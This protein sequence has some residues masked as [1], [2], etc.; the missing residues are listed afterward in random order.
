MP[1]LRGHRPHHPGGHA[2][3]AGRSG[4]PRKRHRRGDPHCPG[5][6]RRPAPHRGGQGLHRHR[7]P[8]T[9]PPSLRRAGQKSLADCKP[10]VK[11]G[12]SPFLTVSRKARRKPCFSR[13]NLRLKEGPNS[14]I[15]LQA[16]SMASRKSLWSVKISCL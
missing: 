15:H 9:L 3:G 13:I 12:R 16:L 10:F 4:Q 1:P 5:G 14:R 6:G 7:H 8:L 11:N 2:P